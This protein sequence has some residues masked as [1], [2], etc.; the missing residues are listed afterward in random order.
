MIL[1]KRKSIFVAMVLFLSGLVVF[2][3]EAQLRFD[4]TTH[5]FGTIA[6]AG[7][8]VECS[9]RATNEGD[10][11]VVILDVV[12]TC[13]CTVPSFSRKPIRA[14]ET[15]EIRV[16]YDPYN[17]PGTIDRKLHVYD[18]NRNRLAVLTLTGQVT[19]R[20]RS[21][22]ER[23]PIALRRGVRLSN[24]LVT[25]T[26]LYIGQPM[27]SALSLINT[28]DVPRAIEL[29]PTT[30]SGLL[31]VEY[32]TRLAAGERSAINFS[33]LVPREQ[34][35]YGTVRD[36]FE[37]WIDG[38]RSEQLLMVHAIVVD[39]PTKSE[40][41]HPAKVELS[42][43]ILKFGAVKAAS[44]PQ[45]RVLTIR[46]AGEGVLRLRKVEGNR[47]RTTFAHEVALA[48]G[49]EHAIEVIFDPSQADYGF[50]SEQLLLI[51]NEPD[52]P[53]RRVRVTATVEE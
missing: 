38:E 42:E 4:R 2:E 44:K 37:V 11:P 47:L 8:K 46:N 29:R 18:A 28:A 14:G 45:R 53:M 16:S 3:A 7:G 41:E 39:R 48:A 24:T 21:V 9:F 27:R 1:V 20:E 6:E 23:Y 13:G 25:F 22:E 52:R 33:Y 32:P 15:A 35:R 51:T 49:E 10:R 30:Q 43:N 12:T 5:N 40:K 50:F 36:L 34:P 19:P 17:R 26:Y 31:E